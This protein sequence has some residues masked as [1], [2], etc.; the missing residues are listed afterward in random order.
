[1]LFRV[2]KLMFGDKNNLK[3]RSSKIGAHYDP[4]YLDHD[5]S[6]PPSSA[7]I[8]YIAN[9]GDCLPYSAYYKL[10]GDICTCGRRFAKRKRHS[11]T[12]V[13]T[14]QLCDGV[15]PSFCPNRSKS[16]QCFCPASEIKWGRV[17]FR[18]VHPWMDTEVRR[19]RACTI[20]CAHIWLM[21]RA[22][23]LGAQ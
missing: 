19:A 1:M 8:C 22:V 21:N 17:N 13:M 20:S 12:L 7:E 9:T 15:Q 18:S 6:F 3:R 10:Q 16:P 5:K 23:I 11:P 4:S 2:V 14:Q